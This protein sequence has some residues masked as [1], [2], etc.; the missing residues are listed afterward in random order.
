ML[1]RSSR[2]RKPTATPH[3]ASRIPKKPTGNRPNIPQYQPTTTN[4]EGAT[5]VSLGSH[6]HVPQAPT[7]ILTQQAQPS[8]I[9]SCFPQSA[10]ILMPIYTTSSGS[11]P[12]GS[13]PPCTLTSPSDY[14][15]PTGSTLMPII[16]EMPD[17]TPTQIPSANTDLA[18]NV[19]KNLIEKIQKGEYVDLAMLLSNSNAKPLSSK[20]SFEQGELV[21][22]PEVAQKKIHNIEQWTSAFIIFTSIYCSTHPNRFQ[23]LLKYMHVV[24]LG[25]DRSATGWKLYDEQFRLRKA[26]DP[27]SSWAQVDY[28]LWLFYM[29]GSTFYSSNYTSLSQPL[30]V[31]NNKLKCYAFN[32]SGRC[33]KQMC[34]FS[35]SCLNCGGFH[36]LKICNYRRPQP[37]GQFN[38]TGDPFRFSNRPYRPSNPG[39]G[40]GIGRNFSSINSGFRQQNS[41]R[42]RTVATPM[43]QGSYPRMR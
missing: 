35:H 17:Q 25:A 4:D 36:S 31:H 26:Q 20:L 7:A 30:Q 38:S 6:V 34:T 16:C 23:E 33:Y 24:R 8:T 40:T 3:V 1:R 42:P 19:S 21:L 15:P 14:Q 22:K 28:E 12:D 29:Q 37:R 5:F 41:Y 10:P 13:P 43:G 27:A 9:A 32:Y 18:S 39:T 11:N 2:K